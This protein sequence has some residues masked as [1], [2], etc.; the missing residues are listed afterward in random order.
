V[1]TSLK[2]TPSSVTV[3]GAGGIPWLKA[4]AHGRR[5]AVADTAVDALSRKF[6][7]RRRRWDQVLP[8]SVVWPIAAE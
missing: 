1:R 8:P 6:V 3:D 4:L 2:V 5:Q 7:A